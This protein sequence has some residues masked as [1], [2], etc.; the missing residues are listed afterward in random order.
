MEPADALESE[1][2]QSS[3][4][5][6]VSQE[7]KSTKLDK[8]AS[9]RQKS[10]ADLKRKEIKFQVGDQVFSK[11][12]PWRKVLSVGK[13]GKWSPCFIGPY[14]VTKRVGSVAYRLP[15]P[16]KLENIHNVF[17]VSMLRR[18]KSDPSHVIAPTEVE[19]HSDMSYGE[20]PVKILARKV[21]QLRNKN[22]PLVKVLWQ[23][24]G[25]K[26]PYGSPKRS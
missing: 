3:I 16:P 4:E 19:I 26:R 24:H 25:L 20:E 21:K 9:D 17:H 10:Y 1:D 6:P 2:V 5:I 18:Y 23:K 15:L 7:L 13:R 14:E 22:V 8:V 11:V 12:S